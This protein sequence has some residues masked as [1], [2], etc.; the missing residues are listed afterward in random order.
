MADQQPDMAVEC[1]EPGYRDAGEHHDREDHLQSDEF[2]LDELADHGSAHLRELHSQFQRLLRSDV[3]RVS[4]MTRPF[5]ALT[6]A[7]SLLAGA[8]TA[9]VSINPIATPV[10]QQPSSAGTVQFGQLDSQNTNPLTGLIGSRAFV[11]N[12]QNPVG[13]TYFAYPYNTY[14]AAGTLSPVFQDPIRARRVHPIRTRTHT[15]GFSG[16]IRTGWSG[17]ANRRTPRR[18][19]RRRRPGTRPR[20]P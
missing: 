11:W 13:S 5:V 6:L 3:V 2:D 7:G 17:P 10:I 20:S 8:A 14:G 19:S 4:V 12:A 15:C 18:R 1:F 16:T 9:Q